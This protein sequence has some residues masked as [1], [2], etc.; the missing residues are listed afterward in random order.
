MKIQ[1]RYDL[2]E[3][4][5]DA[6]K[7]MRCGFCVVLCPIYDYSTW[8]SE[9]PR[10][11]MQ[12][13][14]GIL[15]DELKINDVIKDRMF[16][17]TLCAYCKDKCPAGVRTIDAFKAIRRRL[18]NEKYT[19]DALNMLQEAII[20]SYNIFKHPSEARMDWIEYMDL[21]DKVKIAK[22]A[23]VVYF[24]GCSTTLT[25]R[26]MSIAAST[27][28]ILNALE[29]DWTVLGQDEW[30]CGNPLLAGGKIDGIEEFAKH[31]IDVIKKLGA[32]TVVTSCPGCFKTFFEDYPD[33]LGSLDFKVVHI[34]QLIDKAIGEGKLDF[35]KNL[36][37]TI[38]YHDPCELGRYLGIY[39][40]PRRILKNIPGVKFKELVHNRNLTQCC[41]AGGLM[42][43]TFSN[44]SLEQ[45]KRKIREAQEVGA[46]IITSACQTCKLN[47]LD[48]ITET[49]SDLEVLDITELVA[50]ALNICP[51]EN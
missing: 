22:K 25:G 7:C 26:A 49:E 42:K 15:G 3:Y 13:I 5:L 39:D 48:A 6:Q 29:Y 12:L 40:A 4:R 28:S 21:E 30:C 9:S 36:N 31:N 51:F 32:K 19:P 18:I 2:E 50:K 33:I 23:D 35:K 44:L 46:Q 11:R 14:N 24:T 27:A 8:E 43:A 38:T 17:C 20:E 45:A 47:I 37:C 34:T 1:R 16:E 10:G 41:G